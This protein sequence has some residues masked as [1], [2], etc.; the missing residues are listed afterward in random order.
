M[1]SLYSI[2]ATS[3]TLVAGT[4]KT[5]IQ[6]P[7]SSTAGFLVVA[8]EV[9]S[10]ATAAGTLVIEWMTYA[11]AGTGGATF[12]PLK[13]GT[14]QGVVANLGTVRINDTAEPGTLLVGTLPT[15]VIPL[16][17]MYSILYPAGRE[18]FQPISTN[19]CIRVTSSLANAVRINLV[20]EI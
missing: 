3:V 14:D 16:P 5:I 17:G 10:T 18:F 12:T 2:S 20:V 4:P 13:Y 7:S 11:T 1:A 6:I 8:L 15:W 19:R 9:M